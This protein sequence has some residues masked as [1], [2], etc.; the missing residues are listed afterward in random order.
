MAFICIDGNQVFDS[1]SDFIA[2]LFV[3]IYQYGGTYRLV[4]SNSKMYS[5][6]MMRDFKDTYLS[7]LSNIIK[8]DV[9]SNLNNTLK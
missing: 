1:Y 3:Q 6:K 4:I 9:S 8:M 2:D 5:D 7:I